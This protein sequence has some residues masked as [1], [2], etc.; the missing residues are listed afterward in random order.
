MKFEFLAGSR[1]LTRAA[2]LVLA[3]TAAQGS[4][5]AAQ[6]GFSFTVTAFKQAVAES[7]GDNPEVAAFYRTRGFEPLWTGADDLSAARRSA[8]FE[9][10]GMADDHGLPARRYDAEGLMAQLATAR[11]GRERGLAE[12]AMTRTYLLFAHDLQSG[13]LDPGTLDAGI[14]RVLPRRPDSE[15]LAKLD[16]GDPRAVMRALVPATAEYSRLMREKLLLE[17]R[18]AHG[19]WGDTVPAAKLEPGDSGPAVV[20]LRDRLVRMGHLKPHLGASYD[21]RLTEAVRRV[22]EA[23]GLEPDGVAGAS[24][25]R[26]INTAPEERLQSVIVAMER[27]RWLNLPEG[28]GKRHILVNLVDFHARIMDDDKLTFETRSVIGHQDPDRR[29]P[30]F[31]DLM[32][33]MVI[34][35]SWYV[36]RSIIV[37]EYLPMLRSNPGA[38]SHLQIID[39]RGRVV[40][41]G[42]GF[43]QYSASSFPFS[44]RQPPGPKNA[45]GSVKF[46]FP[47]QYNIYLHDTPSQHLFKEEV[48]T[49]SHGCIRLD[50]PHDF[51]YALLAR[52]TDDPQ[53]LFHRIL[54]TGAETRVNLEQPVPVHLIYRTAFT[55]AK[56]PVN[57]RADVYG[58]DA[59]IWQALARQGVA[60]RAGRS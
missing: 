10:L 14:K 35:P 32:T 8:L 50:D 23:H 49:Y 56:G 59:L 54:N 26:A 15:Q 24:T 4:P 1:R 5:V 12:M 13:I 31:S 25:L 21:S 30:E 16:N 51:A 58:R 57:Y 52:Q 38:V 46:M 37:K 19:G 39:A 20:A 41:R 6:D 2:A 36:P 45:L 3:L 34:N 53:G 48:R 42:N 27:E 9:I 18:I 22:Q 29:T 11:T 55:Q 17:H 47:N 40:G 28:R 44:M 60:L 33:H 43:G 7:L